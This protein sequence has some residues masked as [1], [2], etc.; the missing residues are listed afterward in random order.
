MEVKARCAT[1]KRISSLHVKICGLKDEQMLEA[2]I[3]AGA[4]FVGLVFFEPSPRHV[5]ID[6]AAK[7]ANIARGRAKIV[8]LV[9]DASDALLGEIADQVQP[10]YFQL[11]GHET[12]ER[13]TEI[14]ERFK[15]PLMKAIGV[16]TPEDVIRAN[17]YKPCEIILFDAKAD[18]KLTQLPG[19][20]GIPFDWRLL[21]GQKEQRNFMLSGG[22]TPLNVRE[23][24]KLT[25]ASMI[26][27][28][29]GVET[30]PGEKDSALIAQFIK[31]AK[32][33][34]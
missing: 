32:S 6:I 27:V 17:D 12:A 5:S 10:D 29:S 34:E 15:I 21:T 13:C 26:D 33:E 30:T 11:H 7:L 19:G 9:V 3:E 28:S 1:S 22:L 14:L 31:A 24:I 23:A 25:G 18:P 8:A 16:K 20:N 4:D 2:A